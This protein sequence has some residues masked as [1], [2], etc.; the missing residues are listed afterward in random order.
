M[1]EP[2]KLSEIKMPNL[3]PKLDPEAVAALRD[4]MLAMGTAAAQLQQAMKK[5]A[6]GIMAS[7][8]EALPPRPDYR[9]EW[10]P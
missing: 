1:T 8:A 2:T 4:S 9:E 3:M 10:K 7:V 6:P 5:A